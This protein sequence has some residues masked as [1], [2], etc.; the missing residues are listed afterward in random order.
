MVNPRMPKEWTVALGEGA[1]I[2]AD[3]YQI[4]RD[5]QDAFAMA[6]HQKAAAAW[7]EGRFADE[8][9]KVPDVALE[10]DECIRA[11]S[12][13]ESLARLKPAFRPTG[14]VTAGNSSPLND[15]AAALLLAS[16]SAAS[17]HGWQP[18]ARVV[19]RATSGVEPQLFGIGPVEA[20]QTA[21][22]RAGIGWGDLTAVELNEAFAAQSLSCLAEWPD[23]DP[24]IVNVNG[25]AIALG[26]PLGCSGARI[27]TTLS[28]ELKRRGGGW[29]LAA[30]C[31]GVGQGIAVVV[32]A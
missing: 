31:I 29:G 7:A 28:W 22:A 19:S 17:K 6:S 13:M 18:L 10:R 11:E 27:L 25:G 26:H 9:I 2:L 4:S 8:V 32:Q 14:S 15:G 20:A 16:E 3:R 30:M 1:E 5:A 24:S 12:S 23:L 21:L